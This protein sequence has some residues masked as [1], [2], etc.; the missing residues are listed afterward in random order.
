MGVNETQGWA[1]SVMVSSGVPFMVAL[2]AYDEL[3]ENE[4]H[5]TMGGVDANRR[6]EHLRN[7]IKV[8]ENFVSTARAGLYGNQNPAYVEITRA[9]A[10]G[11]LQSGLEALKMQ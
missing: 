7:S 2:T 6:R 4:N 5:L 1:C 8:L 3:V 10:S 9:L 11:S